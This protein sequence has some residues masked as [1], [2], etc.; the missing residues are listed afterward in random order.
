MTHAD[1]INLFAP[2]IGA[3]ILALAG[4]VVAL[5]TGLTGRLKTYFDSHDEVAVARVLDTVNAAI[6][7]E[8]ETSASVIAGK[9]DRGELDYTDRAAWQKE[10]VSEVAL[11][12]GRLPAMAQVAVATGTPLLTQLMARVDAKAVASPTINAPAPVAAPSLITA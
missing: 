7:K 9:I 11:V 5:L 12:K 10:A 3:V 4:L 8:L 1:W 6:D 2:A